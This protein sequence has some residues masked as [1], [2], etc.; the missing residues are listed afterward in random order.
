MRVHVLSPNYSQL[1]PTPGHWLPHVFAKHH[2]E[3][4]EIDIRFFRTEEKQ[5]TDCDILIVSSFR[6]AP[7]NSIGHDKTSR[8]NT[9]KKLEEWGKKATLIWSDES[10]SSGTTQFEVLPYVSA[11]WKKQLLKN[12]TLYQKNFVSGRTHFDYWANHF[13]FRDTTGYVLAEDWEKAAFANKRDQGESSDYQLPHPLDL[14]YIDR[15]FPSW[16]L[17]YH[18]WRRG[19]VLDKI[20]FQI[21]DKIRGAMHLGFAPP[22]LPPHCKDRSIDIT[23]MFGA[24][25]NRICGQ[26]RRMAVSLLNHSPLTLAS[27]TQRIPIDKYIRTI[28]DTKINLSLFGQGEICYR[29]FETFCAGA[30]L[31]M[32]D[33]SHLECYPDIYLPN[34]TYAPIRWDFSDMIEVISSL[35]SDNERRQYIANNGQ[36]E[37]LKAWSDEGMHQFAQRLKRLLQS[38]IQE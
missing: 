5:L 18:D 29:D 11:Y 33:M 20:K 12:R 25:D 36:K 17:A 31:V 4:L 15:V 32:T 8:E 21:T 16:T 3:K 28:C 13:N 9:L 7:L 38:A 30:A 24:S 19:S 10:D 6:L 14:N 23:A 37:Y 27:S 2:L 22:F 34:E 35:L 26:A 1:R